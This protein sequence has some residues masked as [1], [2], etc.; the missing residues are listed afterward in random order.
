MQLFPPQGMWSDEQ[1]L[2]LQTNRLVELSDGRLEF[3]PMPS[4]EHQD[5]VGLLYR[6]LFDFVSARSLGK[7]L[8]APLRVRLWPGK[9]REPDL[10]FML[11]EHAVRRTNQF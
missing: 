5:L 8:F 4:E 10:V 9:F 7:L 3:P 11:A 2:R 1:Y 6:L